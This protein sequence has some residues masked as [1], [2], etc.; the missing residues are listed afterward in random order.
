MSQSVFQHLITW[1][2]GLLAKCRLRQF[3]NWSIRRLIRKYGVDLSCVEEPDIEKYPDFNAFFTRALKPESRPVDPTLQA[4][5]SAAD[6]F[7]SQIGQ[8]Q[9]GKIIQAKGI[10]YSVDRLLACDARHYRLEDGQFFNVYLSPSDYHRVH[11][12][13]T[14]K[15]KT[16]TY[17]PGNLFSVN[18]SVVESIPDLFV[19]NERVIAL[20]ETSIGYVAIVLVGAM[21]VGKIE[22]VWQKKITS[23]YTRKIKTWDYSDQNIVLNKGEEM[24]RFLLGSTVIAIFPGNKVTWNLAF[25]PGNSVKMGQSLG[26][27]E[28]D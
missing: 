5:V 2:M 28:I 18:P 19:R 11:M 1:Y 27:M 14:G 22:T 25:Q 26:K 15:L 21:V 3:K 23:F 13:I 7:I 24:G 8:L 6:G 4:I 10:H 12:P 9:E 17:V 16:M 20:F